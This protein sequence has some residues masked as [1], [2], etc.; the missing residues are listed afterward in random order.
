MEKSTNRRIPHV[1]HLHPNLA[2]HRADIE[3]GLDELL[4]NPVAYDQLMLQ[5]RKLNTLAGFAA[6]RLTKVSLTAQGDAKLKQLQEMH[7]GDRPSHRVHEVLG[8][9]L[10]AVR[11][12]NLCG[13]YA[14]RR[15]LEIDQP[16][17]GAAE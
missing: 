15:P 5:V 9:A 11:G 6:R 1:P 12:N 3:I 10:L 17:E 13:T 2:P 7:R 16:T 4:M 8:A 14:A